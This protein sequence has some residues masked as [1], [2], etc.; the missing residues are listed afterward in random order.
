MTR[1]RREY[2]IFASWRKTG[3]FA[4]ARRKG[5]SMR[6]FKTLI[7]L[8]LLVQPAFAGRQVTKVD[9]LASLGLEVNAAG[10]LLVRMDAARHR[11]LVA[12]TLSSS[13]TLI[14]C[15][16]RAVRNVP[17]GSRVPQHLKA[18]AL[19]VDSRTGNVYVIGDHAL[20][21]V[22]PERGEAR[23][24]RTNKQFEMVAVDE[25]TGNAFLVGRESRDMAWVDLRRNR[26]RYIP[27]SGT[28]ERAQ[29]LNQTPPP[30]L[31]KVVCDSASRLVG[32]V[33]GYSATLHLFSADGLKPLGKRPLALQPGGRWH[34]AGYSPKQRAIVL[35]VE[36]TERKVIQAAKVSLAGE[37][38]VVV[39]LP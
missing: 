24:F 12:N 7:P 17:V 11:L 25:A 28:E 14:D 30:P 21:V 27:W 36:T 32:A 18:E 34:F 16:D 6:F 3:T 9:L 1:R 10:P 33:D 4:T 15:R 2:T 31:R 22:F 13:L 20:E 19:A 26:V 38:D 29:N 37:Q 39:P 8:M 35:V 23:T 5:G